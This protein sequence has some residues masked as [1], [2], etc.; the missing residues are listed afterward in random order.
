MRRDFIS[1][2]V[3]EQG[4][5]PLALQANHL[6]SGGLAAVSYTATRPLCKCLHGARFPPGIAN[7][8]N[9]IWPLQAF[10]DLTGDLNELLRFCVASSLPR[11]G[12]GRSP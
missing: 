10:P 12:Y 1:G 3:F 11:G 8:P 9:S 7:I 6:F 5:V 2:G 4:I